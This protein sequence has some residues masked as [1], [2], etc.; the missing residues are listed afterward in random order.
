MWRDRSFRYTRIRHVTAV[1][2]NHRCIDSGL[3]RLLA[4][5]TSQKGYRHSMGRDSLSYEEVLTAQSD[6]QPNNELRIVDSYSSQG[7]TYYW[8]GYWYTTL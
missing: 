7:W 4:A 6:N 2:R 1:P 3:Y 5:N 8:E